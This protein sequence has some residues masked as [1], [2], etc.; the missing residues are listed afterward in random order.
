[1]SGGGARP[2]IDFAGLADALLQRAHHLLPEWLPGGRFDGHEYLGPPRSAGGHG[3][4]LKINTNNGRWAL[5]SGDDSD[6]GSDLTSLYAWLNNL[7][8]AKA[9]LELM[10]RLGWRRAQDTVHAAPTGGPPPWMDDVPPPGGAHA[11]P[12]GVPPGSATAPAEPDAVAP[13]GK[14]D[15]W[16]NVLPVPPHARP[17]TRFVFPF[18]NDNLKAWVELEATRVWE[19]RFE[20]QLFGYV[21]RFERFNSAGELVKD[22]VPY[23]WCEDTYDDRR[24]QRWHWRT[25]AEPRPLYIPATLLSGTPADVPVV[26]VEGEKCAEAGH[27]LLGHEF[28]FVSW[29]GGSRS[30]ALARWGWLM[31]RTVYLWPDV[32][33]KR[34]RLTKAEREAQVDPAIKPLLP[35]P[36][37]PGMQAMVGIGQLLLAEQACT[38]HMCPVPG[39]GKVADGWDIAD[40][41]AEGWDAARVRDFIRSARPFLPPDEAVRAKAGDPA[42]ADAHAKSTPSRAAADGGEDADGESLSWLAHLLRSGSGAVRNVRENIVMALDGLPG[43]KVRGIAECAGLI[44]FNEFSNTIEKRRPTPWGTPAGDWIEA[45]ELL[46]GDWLVREH[47]LPS[48]PRGALEEAVM[49]VSRRYSFHPLR[50]CMV[51]LRGAWDGVPRLDEWLGRLC[52]ADEDLNPGDLL[53]RYLALAGRWFV[54]GMVA[55]VMPIKKDGKRVVVGPGTKFD[56]MLVFEGPQG[57][58]KSSAAAVLGGEYFADTGLDLEHKDSLMNIQGVWVYEWSELENLS[59]QEVGA[60]KRFISSPTDRF[61]ATFDRRPAKYPRQVVFVGTTNESHYL[62][63]QTGNRRFWPVRVTRPPDLA[64]LRE[65]LEQLFAEAVHRVDAGERFWPTRE[66]QQLLFDPQ[67]RA[68]RVESGMEAAIRRY[69]YDEQQKVFPGAQNGAL[70]PEIGMSELLTNIGFST[71]KQTDA[72]CK[73]AGQVLHSLGWQVRRTSLP[74]RPRVYV[75]PQRDPDQEPGASHGPADGGDASPQT[76]TDDDCPF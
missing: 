39:P 35:E 30:W 32:D 40:A 18:K 17:P 38:V 26:V 33:A 22:T 61:R 11:Q 60:V 8:Q 58:G 24:G 71:D 44:A 73:R 9:A 20:G 64:W 28:D 70:V 69:L 21:C 41:I 14:R 72:I 74:G 51:A 1:M 37:Q 10:D 27:Q 36:K 43:R 19:Y 46:M 59:K 62:T 2:L 75:R 16:R 65:N 52:L 48:T 15:R 45:D 57:W 34:V 42:A 56:Y 68:R 53:G 63:D 47:R 6:V 49:V 13:A 5:F 66:E 76:E 25:W 31:G 55:R 23:T 67:Q 29:P 12:A 4:S 50:D 54:M 3:D 7:T